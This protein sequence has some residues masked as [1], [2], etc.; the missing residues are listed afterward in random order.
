MSRPSRRSSSR[1]SDSAPKK[2]AART[3][4]TRSKRE[5]V[6]EDIEELPTLEP[7]EDD[8][9]LPTLE[10]MEDDGE[11]LETLEPLAEDLATVTLT[12]PDETMDFEVRLDVELID[13]STPKTEVPDAI[14]GP[15]VIAAQTHVGA[16]RW[17]RVA[18]NFVGDAMIPSAAK[19]C[20]ATALADAK[21]LS[22]IVQR[23]YGDELVL[24]NTM[25]TLSVEWAEDTGTI[26]AA[27]STA[28]VDAND[29]ESMLPAELHKREK[30]LT[31][32]RLVVAFD[33]GAEILT[34]GVRSSLRGLGSAASA[35]TV[36]L[37]TTDGEMTLFDK[38]LEERVRIG[39]GSDG[40]DLDFRV[41]THGDS[42]RFEQAMDLALHN[43]D[44]LGGKRIA[45]RAAGC[46]VTADERSVLLNRVAR[47]KPAEIDL[48]DTSGTTQIFPPLL[49]AAATKS[50]T[51]IRVQP[52]KRD[53]SGVREAFDRELDRMAQAV[54]KRTVVVDWP[55]GYPLNDSL[56][57]LSLS[58]LAKR[59]ASRV[60]F[61]FGGEHR[62]PMA[63]PPLQLSESGDQRVLEIDTD[64]G[65]PPELIRAIDRH[66][67]T[68]GSK[69]SGKPVEVR[70]QGSG[71]V[72]RS[73]Q[74]SL[75]DQTA[76]AGAVRCVLV[77]QGQSSY[78]FPSMLAISEVVGGTAVDVDL[79]GRDAEQVARALGDELQDADLD[80]K[81]VML[82]PSDHDA[83][84]CAAIVQKGAATVSLGGPNPRRLHPSMMTAS[85]E[86]G[87]LV[88]S[89][90]PAA[91]EAAD[92][93]SLHDALTDVLATT[94]AIQETNIRV[95]WPEATP[96]YNRAEQ[97]KLL[98]ELVTQLL[99]KGPASLWIQAGAQ[100]ALPVSPRGQGGG[101][102]LIGE[103][104]SAEP[105]LS[106]IGLPPKTEEA[107]ATLGYEL[108]TEGPS[109][110][111]HRVLITFPESL[112]V[113][114]KD[115]PTEKSIDKDSTIAQ[116]IDHV[117][118]SSTAAVLLRQNDDE[119][120]WFE[121]VSSNH[122]ALPIGL[123]VKDPRP[124]PE[125]EEPVAEESAPTTQDGDDVTG[126]DPEAFEAAAAALAGLATA[127]ATDE[128]L[129]E[130]EAAE[131]DNRN[132]GDSDAG[133]TDSG[134]TGSSD[135][136]DDGSV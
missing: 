125:P 102:R 49:A 116:I 95:V 98:S 46:D 81:N 59:K 39:S 112:P 94:E 51:T 106:L 65:K 47:Q 134:D 34:R 32:K 60:S 25:P 28:E 35:N 91:D 109:F 42:D 63:P 104:S 80:G 53:H 133:A 29:L 103:R 100:P 5:E 19:E 70:V 54:E 23:G 11:E 85:T 3:S 58:S 69:L 84:I 122:E 26:T 37:R 110:S 12:V 119:K 73:M 79:A 75:R 40:Y 4:R 17:K 77:E 48:F 36:D 108:L 78:L 50:E 92:L 66:L 33:C 27:V 126:G 115:A 72:S 2:G 97:P 10:P 76:Q 89:V 117:L 56:Q 1:K 82:T 55:E 124:A 64:A 131:G 18:V 31:N 96:V 52:G 129:T 8:E 45:V 118:G 120:H 74:R 20:I 86:D 135:A 43:V 83:A 121:V 61:T 16:I 130:D 90:T 132:S 128:L 41:R 9:E 93:A 22:V 62:E 101:I 127:A 88:L 38:D 67:R 136:G 123:R 21:P 57:A 6:E 105:P 71:A 87:T 14:E 111:G 24:E 99:A 114:G 68:E 107:V 15:L 13:P 7:I 44:P 30:D 113:E